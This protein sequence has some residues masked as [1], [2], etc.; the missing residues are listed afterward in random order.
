MS[1]YTNRELEILVRGLLDYP[2][3]QTW[4]EFKDGNDN[5]ERIGKYISALAKRL[6]G[7]GH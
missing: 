7:L 2:S 1:K 6:S 5:P 4:F 3:E